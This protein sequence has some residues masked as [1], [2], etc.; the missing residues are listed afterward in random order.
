MGYLSYH[1][2]ISQVVTAVV[3]FADDK[4]VDVAVL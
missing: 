2:A 3:L 1:T 4:E